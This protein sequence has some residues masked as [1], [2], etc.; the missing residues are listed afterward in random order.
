MECIAID[1]QKT[2]VDEHIDT[3]GDMIGQ[4]DEAKMEKFI[5]TIPTIIQTHL[6]ICPDWKMTKDKAKELEHIIR[7]CEPLAAVEP[8]S[9][10]GTSVPSLYSHIGQSEDKED[11]DIPKPFKGVKPKQTKGKTRGKPKQQSKQTSQNIEMQQDE[12]S[13]QD[14]NN[15]YHTDNYRG[16]S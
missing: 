15:Y 11:I 6:V 1:P 14:P 16:Q 7:K 2:D 4:K 5:D 10:T 13:Y 8:T 12:Y 3:L 9:A